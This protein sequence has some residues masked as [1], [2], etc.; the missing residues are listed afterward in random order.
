[1]LG[2][3]GRVIRDVW[4]SRVMNGLLSCEKREMVEEVHCWSRVLGMEDTKGGIRSDALYYC[5]AVEKRR[6]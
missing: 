6:Y 2:D 5:G 4:R 1:M 3:G